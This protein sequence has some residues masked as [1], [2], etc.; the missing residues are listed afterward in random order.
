ML[1]AELGQSIA[2]LPEPAMDR[3]MAQM[4]FAG[5][6]GVLPV[7]AGGLAAIGGGEKWLTLLPLLQQ[8]ERRNAA[9]NRSFLQSIRAA[10]EIL[11][12]GGLRPVFLKGAALLLSDESALLWRTLSDI[13]LL[14]TPGEAKE[15]AVLLRNAGYSE[16]PDRNH[17]GLGL[18]HHAAPLVDPDTGIAVELH[19]RIAKYERNCILTTDEI[20]RDAELKTLHGIPGLAPSPAHRM[21]HLI[22]HAQIGNLG[23]ALK[24]IFLRDIYEAARLD[25]AAAID[26]DAV[27]AA[28]Q[29]K[30]R[31]REALS[32]LR[33]AHE[34]L[35][36]DVALPNR[37]LDAATS[38]MRSA[39]R[40]LAEPEPRWRIAQRLLG[41]YAGG[42]LRH[43]NR[44]RSLPSAVFGSNRLK[45]LWKKSHQQ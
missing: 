21:I 28:F 35:G 29:A 23:Y 15:A 16:L 41:Y 12:G 7:L 13:D 38:W 43:P 6:H 26:W 17:F 2:A 9:R 30:G 18:H 22:A 25:Q 40:N 44:L 5:H 11:S 19:T 8:E 3:F 32:F 36:L 42:I 33:A 37:D 4:K 39:V 10:G 24:S 1:R 31:N 27:I 14:L 20:A 45:D 34:L